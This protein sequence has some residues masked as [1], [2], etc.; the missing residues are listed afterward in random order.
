MTGA[1]KTSREGGLRQ[2]SVGAVALMLKVSL[3][4]MEARGVSE[5]WLQYLKSI[6]EDWLSDGITGIRSCTRMNGL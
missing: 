1:V 4:V 5:E 2:I 6:L 3:A